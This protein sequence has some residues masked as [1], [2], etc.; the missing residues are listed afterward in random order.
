MRRHG[1]GLR[2]CQGSVDALTY[3]LAALYGS[4]G[5]RVVAVNPGTIDTQLSADLGP[6]DAM[7]EL[8]ADCIDHTPLGRFGQPEEIARTIAWL[9]SSDAS[10]VTGT[11]IVVDGGLC[12]APMG[13]ESNG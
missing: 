7:R 13:C 9:A 10:F 11:T 2:G 12:A 8:V 6:A 4:R 3:E 5:I 1:R